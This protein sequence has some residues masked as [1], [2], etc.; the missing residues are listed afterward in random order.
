MRTSCRFG[1]HFVN[2]LRGL[3]ADRPGLAQDAL[4]WAEFAR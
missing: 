3:C 2:A 1:A 4:V